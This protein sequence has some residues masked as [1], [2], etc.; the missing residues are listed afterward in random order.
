MHVCIEYVSGKP[1][2]LRSVLYP[3]GPSVGRSVG[4]LAGRP[5]GYGVRAYITRCDVPPGRG[6]VCDALYFT[7]NEHGTS[8]SRAFVM[9]CAC[10]YRKVCV[11]PR[12]LLSLS[13]P[14]LSLSFSIFL[15]FLS[16]IFLFFSFFF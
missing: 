10:V 3:V 5:A 12:V 15:L 9:Q 2:L 13:F 7:T 1:A 14:L 8:H 4:R 16:K 6:R 11:Y